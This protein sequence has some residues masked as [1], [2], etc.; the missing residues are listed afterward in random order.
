MCS[1]LNAKSCSENKLFCFFFFP[2]LRGMVLYHPGPSVSGKRMSFV[3][4]S[5]S[6]FRLA[7]EGRTNYSFFGLKSEA[8][9]LFDGQRS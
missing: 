3:S 6:G 9:I 7:P 5:I 8:A 1:K 2:A 4:N